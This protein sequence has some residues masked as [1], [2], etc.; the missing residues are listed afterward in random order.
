M[1]L[2]EGHA[3]TRGR[4][5]ANLTTFSNKARLLEDGPPYAEFCFKADGE[6]LK[7]RLRE[8]IRSRGYGPWVSVATSDNKGV[9]K[10]RRPQLI[11]GAPVANGGLQALE[12]HLG[13]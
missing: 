8:Y 7:L 13:I 5:I 2:V 1:T 12:I 6:V 11:G 4:W 3:A 9:T 10:Q